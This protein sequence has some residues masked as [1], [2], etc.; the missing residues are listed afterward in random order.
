MA[1]ILIIVLALAVLHFMYESLL[2][3][4]IRTKLRFRLFGIRDDLRMLMAESGNDLDTKLFHYMQDSINTAVAFLQYIDLKALLQARRIFREDPELCER[5]SKRE[6]M[7]DA[8]SLEAF[9]VIKRERSKLFGYAL[10]ANSAGFFVYAVPFVIVFLLLC[11]MLRKL[12][13]HLMY[14]KCQLYRFIKN[15]T[16]VPENELV[17]FNSY[18]GVLRLR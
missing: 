2:L 3:P 15:L 12:K 4:S 14:M 6:A 16:C 13:D 1:T 9:Q 7:I 10:L 17:K 5:A 8:C 18:N 11:V